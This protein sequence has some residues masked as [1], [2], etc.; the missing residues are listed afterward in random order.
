MPPYS[1]VVEA[2][3]WLNA[4]KIFACFSGA[5]PMPVSRTAKCRQASV[6]VDRFRLDV[7]DD[8]PAAGELDGV[9]DEVDND[10]PQPTGVADEFVGHIRRDMHGQL[11]PLCGR[12]G[13]QRVQCCAERFPQVERQLLQLQFAGFDLGE[14]ENVVEHRQQRVGRRFDDVLVFALFGGEVGIEQAARS[15]R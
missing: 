4:S 10:L 2:S 12:A 7:N 15:F 8:F 13:R 5:M 9:A 6:R 14:V 11:Q 3:A 1:R